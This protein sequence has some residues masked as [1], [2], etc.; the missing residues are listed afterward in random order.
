MSKPGFKTRLLGEVLHTLPESDGAMHTTDPSKICVCNPMILRDL[1]TLVV[2][3][4]NHQQMLSPGPKMYTQ[5]ELDA[6]VKQAKID[7]LE[8]A[9]T[10]WSAHPIFVAWLMSFARRIRTGHPDVMGELVYRVQLKA[11]ALREYA[12]DLEKRPEF[13][14]EPLK[15]R[16]NRAKALRRRA[17]RIEGLGADHED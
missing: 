11:A 16:M 5:E 3:R 13:K 4:I 10:W 12:D 7:I 8:E 17:D 9:A 1:N 15:D 6:E 14:G 2:E